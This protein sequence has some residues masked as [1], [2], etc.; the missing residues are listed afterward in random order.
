MDSRQT[1]QMLS[2]RCAMQL[3]V[4]AVRSACWPTWTYGWGRAMTIKMQSG[5]KTRSVE[6]Q[7]AKLRQKVG[8]ARHVPCL[9]FERA[10][11]RDMR[12]AGAG[13]A[14]T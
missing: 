11:T 12:G 9:G 1:I 7:L 4:R 3:Q 10:L 8:S 13:T 6:E 14:G 2:R 5:R